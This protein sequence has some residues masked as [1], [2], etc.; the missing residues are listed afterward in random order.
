MKKNNKFQQYTPEDAPMN[1]K[2]RPFYGL[3]LDEDQKIFR[4]AIYDKEKLIVVCN[5]RAGSGKSLISLGVANI[6]VQYGFYDG[7][8]YIAS[9]TMEQRQG[10][11]PGDQA[12]KSAPYMEPLCEA[13]V[14]LGLDPNQVIKSDTNLEALKNGTAYIDFT[15]DTYLRGCN[16]ENKVVIIDEAQ[17]FYFDDLKKTLT[18]IHD[19][20]KTILIGHTLQCDLYK[21]PE[22]SGFKPYLDAFTECNDKRV[23]V[24]KL[25]KNHRGWLSNFCDD[26]ELQAHI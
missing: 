24:C 10:Y 16:F 4:D 18:R 19:N 5:S 14:T 6:L 23:Q 11:L 22:R 8:V 25:T 15:V 2:D 21:K 20:C 3:E 9:P 12:S 1:L 17:N 26:V 13:L 7:I